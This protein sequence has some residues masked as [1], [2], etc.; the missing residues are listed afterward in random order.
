MSN[1]DVTGSGQAVNI[2]H[3]GAL[4]VTIDTLSS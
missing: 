4:N 3:G 1:V 2:S